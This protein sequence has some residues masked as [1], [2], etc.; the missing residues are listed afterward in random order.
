MEIERQRQKE[1]TDSERT[2]ARFKLLYFECAAPWHFKTYMWTY[3]LTF[4][5]TFYLTSILT[6]YLP[7]YLASILAFYLASICGILSDIYSGILSAILS[8]ILSGIYFGILSDIFSGI[9]SDI[10]YSGILSGTP[11]LWGTLRSST[12]RG[13]AGKTLILSL[14]FGSGGE[15]C[16]LALAVE[17]RRRRRRRRRRRDSL[18]KI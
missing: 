1:K 3:I 11:Q 14:L 18:H 6:F 9:L 10:I 4:Y 8:G 12:C 17:V 7:F 16:D 5:P 2:I 13:P 15:H